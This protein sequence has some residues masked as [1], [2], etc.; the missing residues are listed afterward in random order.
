MTDRKPTWL[1]LKR[2]QT[3]NP[4]AAVRPMLTPMAE[5]ELRAAEAVPDPGGV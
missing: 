2:L 4:L 3:F 5:G 1:T